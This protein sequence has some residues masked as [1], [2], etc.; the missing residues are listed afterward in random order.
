MDNFELV[1]Y[2][3]FAQAGFAIILLISALKVARITGM[4]HWH[5]TSFQFHF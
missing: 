4:S 2:K 5:P 1:S 3:L